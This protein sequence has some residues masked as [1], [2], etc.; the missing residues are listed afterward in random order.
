MNLKL[1][2]EAKENFEKFFTRLKTEEEVWRNIIC[3]AKLYHMYEIK[4]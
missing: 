4:N 3:R 2:R 1:R